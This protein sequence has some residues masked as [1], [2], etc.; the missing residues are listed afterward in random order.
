MNFINDNFNISN[1]SLGLSFT[2]KGLNDASNILNSYS[3]FGLG[4]QLLSNNS[5]YKEISLVDTSNINSNNYASLRFTIEQSQISLKSIT[6]N[7]VIRPLL[8]NSNIT[9]ASNIGIGKTIP[10]FNLDALCNINTDEYFIKGVNIS[11]VFPNSNNLQTS[12]TNLSNLTNT[13]VKSGSLII[14]TNSNVGINKA[15]PT[16]NLDVVGNINFTGNLTKNGVIFNNFSG[17]YEDL[18][19]RPNITW[20]LGNNNTYN[21]NI[22]NVGI[23][24]T[25][26]SYKLDVR[27]DVN[28]SGSL[29]RNGVNYSGN[30]NTLE[31]KPTLAT[32]ATTGLY[33]DLI[34]KPSTTGGLSGI[35]VNWNDIQFKPTFASIATT[36]SYNSLSDKP[37]LFDGNYNSLVG[38]PAQLLTSSSTNI[39]TTNTGNFGIKQ[40]SPQ[41]A[42]DINGDINF[43]GN[44][45]KGGAIFGGDW[46]TIATKPALKS[47]ATTGH[48]NDIV[49]KPEFFSGAYGSL[50]GTPTYFKTDWNT[51]ID[52]K[53]TYFKADW[54]TTIDNRP[55]LFSGNW[56]NLSG[57]PTFHPIAFSGRWSDMVDSDKPTLSA[58]AL[59]GN[60][61]DL[62]FKPTLF[63]GEYNDLARKPDLFNG[64]YNSLTNAP[65][66]AFGKD[67]TTNNIKTLNSGNLGIGVASPAYKLE[68]GGDM[69]LTSGYYYRLNG[70]TL[71]NS[72]ATFSDM[73]IKKNINDIEDISA[74]TKIMKI[75]PKTYN[76]IDE[77]D[78]GS[79]LVI[80]FIAQQINEVIPEAITIGQEFIPNIYRYYKIISTNSILID[81]E[82]YIK[83]NIG[84]TIKIRVNNNYQIVKVVDKINNVIVIDKDIDVNARCLVYGVMVNDFHFIDKTYI[85]TLNVC[86][87]QELTRRIE[88]QEKEISELRQMIINLQ[89]GTSV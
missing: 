71:T 6:S 8:I 31:G 67:G 51:T 87:T 27:G 35:T 61:N 25:I 10:L 9:I 88:Q 50:T 44:I 38:A 34:G 17:N 33:D 54:L 86:A 11:N 60:Y 83:I 30:W 66:V 76:Y 85:Y 82:Y 3:R 32:V 23:G 40:S 49:G 77:D 47:I 26:P 16:Y 74:L 59:S 62:L 65:Y 28:F 18:N 19:N 48:W 79:K 24:S 78:R 73:R 89:S 39:Y 80:G 41:Y 63:S 15:N 21:N 53:P 14:Y 13:W 56:E 45:R 22:G 43:T 84:N 5:N 69:N 81:D 20:T 55:T 57:K 64:D 42:L 4:F 52:G 70:T 37:T 58:V 1:N 2:G 68:V 7:N 46:N 72:T 36:G 12:I 29:Y 75:E